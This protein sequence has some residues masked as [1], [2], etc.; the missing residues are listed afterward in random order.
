MSC[1]PLIDDKEKI[2]VEE[3]DVD[4]KRSERH[5]QWQRH[6][7]QANELMSL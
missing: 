3:F 4:Q 5:R 1:H 6:V 2:V 7:K